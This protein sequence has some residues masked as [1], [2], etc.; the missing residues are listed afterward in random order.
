MEGGNGGG[1]SQRG[2]VRADRSRV[3]MLAVS[4]RASITCPSHPSLLSGHHARTRA[5]SR[6][7]VGSSEAISTLTVCTLR[8]RA[9]LSRHACIPAMRVSSR[10][11]RVSISPDRPLRHRVS[12]PIAFCTAIALHHHRATLALPTSHHAP[13]SSRTIY[14]LPLS[15]LRCNRH[16][17]IAPCLC[18]HAFT[19]APHL[20]SQPPSTRHHPPR[21]HSPLPCTRY[22]QAVASG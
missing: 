16:A 6:H 17:S 15:A 19:H 4:L 9:A 21:S 1:G 22:H 2:E 13:P 11:M 18:Y 14:A 5:R 10:A 20:H 8:H 7:L 12:T 3:L